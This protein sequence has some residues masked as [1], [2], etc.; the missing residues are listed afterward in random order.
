MIVE[1]EFPSPTGGIFR[2]AIHLPDDYVIS[3]EELTAMQNSR[4]AQWCAALQ[5][6]AVEEPVEIEPTEEES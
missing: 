2:D 1:F 5:A 6:P 4:F 3:D